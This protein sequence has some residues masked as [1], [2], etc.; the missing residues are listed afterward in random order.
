VQATLAEYYR[1]RGWE[2]ASGRPT[3]EKLTELGL[4]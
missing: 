1:A 2:P 4:A 3:S